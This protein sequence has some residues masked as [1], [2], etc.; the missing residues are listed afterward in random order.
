MSVITLVLRGNVRSVPFWIAPLYAAIISSS[1]FTQTNTDTFAQLEFNFN[2]PGA[3]SAG[4]GGAFISI[5]DDATAAVSNPAGLTSLLQP[6]ISFEFKGIQYTRR[7]HFFSHVGSA[8]HF[9]LQSKDFKNSVVSPSFASAVLPI[10]FMTLSGFRHELVNYESSYFTRGVFVANSP[11][12]LQ[13]VI[14]NPTESDLDLK[15]VNWGAAIGF[16]LDER[17]SVGVSA[18]LSRMTVQSSLERYDLEI[19]EERFLTNRRTIDDA[20][21]DV[22]VNVGFLYRPFSRLSIGGVYKKRPEFAFRQDFVDPSGVFPPRTDEIGF[23]IPESYGFGVSFRPLDVLTLSFDVVRI[24]YAD[25]SKDLA[26][27]SFFDT[28]VLAAEDYTTKDGTEW[29]FGAEYV[30]FLG[31]LGVVVRGGA[32]FDPEHNIRWVGETPA[33]THNFEELR[34]RTFQRLIFTPG[35]EDWHGTFGLGLLLQQNFQVDL[36]GNVSEDSDEFVASFVYRF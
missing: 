20:D 28:T 9:F 18:G 29:H 17:L 2:N 7:I 10:K 26:I 21:K 12:A 6:E 3:R 24:N 23:N 11:P 1:G 33:D 36:A 19:F 16:R 5:A 15:V 14:V 22:F 30:T 4:I 8:T 13:N 34:A 32:F 27:T 35:R 31:P 25:L